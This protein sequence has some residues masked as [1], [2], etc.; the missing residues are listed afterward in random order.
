MQS[1]RC[2]PRVRRQSGEMHLHPQLHR[3]SH[4][5]YPVNRAYKNRANEMQLIYLAGM[6]SYMFKCTR[7]RVQPLPNLNYL[8]DQQK[9]KAIVL[10][11]NL[12]L[13]ASASCVMF[14]I[15]CYATNFRPFRTGFSGFTN[16]IGLLIITVLC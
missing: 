3:C 8:V 11:S 16:R 4:P 15:Q 13:F 2:N 1:I 7:D 10:K 14:T 5:M 6:T 9:S 12:A